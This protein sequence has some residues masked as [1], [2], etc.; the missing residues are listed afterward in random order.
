MH[1]SNGWLAHLLTIVIVLTFTGMPAIAQAQ[2]QQREDKPAP[3]SS[4]MHGR[5]AAHFG[6]R[7]VA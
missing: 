1:A 7:L 2:E 3:C 6:R 5:S 4:V